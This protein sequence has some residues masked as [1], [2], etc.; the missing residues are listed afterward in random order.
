MSTLHDCRGNRL[1]GVG[2]IS[3]AGGA[4]HP[5]LWGDPAGLAA[6]PPGHRST[7]PERERR[8]CRAAIH[9]LLGIGVLLGRSERFLNRIGTQ[10]EEVVGTP[11]SS[12][13]PRSPPPWRPLPPTQTATS[14]RRATR[15]P[16]PRRNHTQ[17]CWWN[18]RRDV[19]GDLP[20]EATRRR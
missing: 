17:P 8:F 11:A 4:A 16:A 2:R 13:P 6:D 1:A 15:P 10:A 9:Q 3:A 18:S 5:R 14:D 12:R 20:P 7:S 19:R